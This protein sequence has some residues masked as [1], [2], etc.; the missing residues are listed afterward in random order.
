[1]QRLADAAKRTRSLR[2]LLEKGAEALEPKKV[3][4]HWQ[5]PE[6]SA[7][8]AARA[9]KMLLADGKCA[10]IIP[11]PGLIPTFCCVVAICSFGR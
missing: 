8:L 9:R 1:M 4:E 3:G 2:K 6:V 7:K 10:I 11:Y 5:K